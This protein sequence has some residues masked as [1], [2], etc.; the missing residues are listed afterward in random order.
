MRVLHQ[1]DRS[2]FLLCSVV[3]FFVLTPFLENDQ[4]GQ[5]CLVLSLYL[6]LVSATMEL[7]EKRL[8]FWSAVPLAGVSM[9]LILA[10]HL[11]RTQTL[12][13]AD[14]LVLAAF[15]GLVVAS[16]FIYLG[17]TGQITSGR[18]YVSVALYF[19]LGMCWFAVYT[20]INA[21]QPGSFA[22]S[23]ATLVGR[24]APSKMLYFSL[25]TLT[26]LG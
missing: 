9:T 10:D 16:L 2:L 5:L 25:T 4:A 12:L 15:C 21:L 20:F 13:I 3:L 26:T 14:H 17:R 22:E 1:E 6:T 24:I 23:G 8:L 19:L 7:A 18:L 11:Y